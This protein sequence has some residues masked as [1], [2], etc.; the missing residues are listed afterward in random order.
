MGRAQRSAGSDRQGLISRN[1]I[2][3]S[4]QVLRRASVMPSPTGSATDHRNR[5]SQQILHFRVHDMAATK[6]LT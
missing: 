2:S 3:S 1:L 4:D 6:A 5:S